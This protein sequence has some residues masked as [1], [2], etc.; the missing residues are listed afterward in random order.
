MDSAS[1][2]GIDAKQIWQAALG[3]LQLQMTK[4][5]FDTWLKG[6]HAI[7]YEDG[8]FVI[9][10]H[11]TYAKEWLENR[12]STPIRRTLCGLL[13]RSVEVR[14]VVRPNAPPVEPTPLFPKA[15]PATSPREK[16]GSSAN[17]SALRP[18]M[19]NPRYTFE[20]FI[21]GSSNRMAHAAALAVAENPARQYNPLFIY[22]GVGLGKTHL[23]HAVGHIPLRR[24][25]RVLYIPSEQFTNDLI[26]AIRTQTTEEFRHKYRQVDVLL[27]DDIQFIAGKESTQEEFFH[28]F[29]TLHEADK[30]IVL[31]SDRPPRAIA[32][33]E[34]R[35]CSR[36]Q[37]GLTVDI[38]PPDLETRIAILRFKSESQPVPVPSEVIEFIAHKIQHNIRELEGA[39]NQVVAHA[40]WMGHP[41]TVETAT[42]AL[43]DLLVRHEPPTLGEILAVVADFYRVDPE[44]LRGRGR[45][46][47]IALP[48]QVAMYLMRTEAHASLPQIGQE[49]GGRDH[50]TVLYGCEKIAARQETDEQLR[51]DLL[52]IKEALYNHVL[53]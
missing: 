53:R 4:A 15:S 51:R 21:V 5:T 47:G 6:T 44:Q 26:N 12:L 33:L 41:L 16:R 40:Q 10:T 50:T 19:L 45:S 36:F 32:T 20:T 49:L 30:Q 28:T 25:L 42:A 38:Q 14:F 1:S 22:G 43:R 8:T 17:P 11:N 37:W 52:A 2:S 3:E 34:E 23:L 35:L 27:V 29:N 39:L 24:N 31:T 9:G 7:A 48:R 46:K 13:G 18:M